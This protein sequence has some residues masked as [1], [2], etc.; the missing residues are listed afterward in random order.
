MKQILSAIACAAMMVAP[1]FAADPQGPG[2]GQGVCEP[3]G[4]WL[5]VSPGWGMQWTL[6]YGSGTHWTGP[7]TL[8][9]IGGDPS[10]GG[11]LPA[12]TY[13]ST[14]GTWVRTGRRTFE[15]TMITYGLGTDPVTGLTI[16]IYIGKNTGITEMSGHCD[17]LVSTSLSVELYSP[18][19]D[20]F[21][22]DPPAYGC[23]P[24]FSPS[25]AQRMTVDSPCE[26]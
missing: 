20:P 12:T 22:D 10:F 3:T 18:D 23:I 21:G 8:Q 4:A 14:T 24:D 2:G 1:V 5:G 7:F 16:P 19:Q 25:P 6:V 9:F 15:Y 26:P 13:S 11:G 17:S